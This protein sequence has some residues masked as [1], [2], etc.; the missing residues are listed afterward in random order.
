M[1]ILIAPAVLLIPFGMWGWQGIA[2]QARMAGK[3]ALLGGY[4]L[5]MLVYMTRGSAAYSPNER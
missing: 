2:W 4:G 3:L 5:F 1:L